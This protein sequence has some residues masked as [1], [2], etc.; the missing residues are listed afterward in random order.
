MT[1]KLPIS[2]IV[3]RRL[4]EL[5]KATVLA[6]A[7]A[8]SAMPFAAKAD[9]SFGGTV[10]PGGAQFQGFLAATSS[11]AT[12]AVTAMNTGFQ[13]QTSAFVYSPSSSQP[14][15]FASGFWG[16]A[17]GGRMDTDSVSVGEVTR[18]PNDQFST[19]C[20]THTRN[21]YNGVQ[22]GYDFGRVNLGASGW[23]AHLGVTGGFFETEATSQQG[24]GTT[25]SGVPFVGLYAALVSR[26]GF[27][28]D[29]QVAGQFYNLSVSEPSIAAQGSMNGRGI[30]I[31]SSAGYNIQLGNNYFIEPS[32]GVVYS[33][34]HLDPL[35]T[36][37]TVLG[38]PNANT[39][40]TL[41]S[42]L[43]LGDIETLPARAGIRVGTTFDA[44]GVSVS[45]FVTASVWHE[46][47]GNTTASATFIPENPP[48]RAPAPG[49]FNIS[50]TRIGT[51]GQYS[52]GVSASVPGTGWLG[53]AR[54]DYRNGENIEAL[55][56]NGGL[57]YQF[58]PA[59][60][61]AAPPEAR[62]YTKAPVAAPAPTWTGVYLGGFAGGAWAGNVTATELAPDPGVKAF[63]NGTGTQ[64]SYDLGS[65]A[66]GGLTFGYNYQTGSLVAGLE[67]EG[68]YLRLTGSAPFSVNPA[69]VSSA[70]IGDWYTALAGRLGF[71][72][73]PALIYGKGG[74][75]IVDVTDSVIDG[76]PQCTVI[77]RSV[78]AAGGNHLGITWVAG[79]GLEYALSNK[80]SVKGEYLALGTDTSN[81]ASGPGLIQCTLANPCTS[82]PQIF[83][84][85]HD[86]PIVQTAKIGINYKL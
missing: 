13:T 45:P 46:F 57:R 19:T 50:S 44:G 54:V 17:I 9:C 60:S 16:R 82:A 11:A 21:D 25:R 64:S 7:I 86:L 68:G 83:N 27:F 56:V 73:G 23:N 81:T 4:F 1:S 2:N 58:A 20:S 3:S 67:A 49:T 22:G 34:V 55:S 8:A 79:A 53:Y 65:S 77:K 24:S 85:R 40:V 42:T 32:V 36:S 14:D 48:I 37:P 30:G 18:K 47:A 66:I 43:T 72:F 78:A 6:T 70:H 33:K 52:L 76:C 80:W 62:M 26:S 31:T 84:W 69:T 10:G 51:F 15:Q 63:F 29:A 71:S 61:V 12:S 75:A 41:P 28:I 38:T 74:A 35:N 5:Q 59:P 39:L